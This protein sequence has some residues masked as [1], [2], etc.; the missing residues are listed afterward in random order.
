VP[1]ARAPGREVVVGAWLRQRGKLLAA[2][3]VVLVGVLI[4]LLVPRGPATGE[5]LVNITGPDGTAV[6]GVKVFLDERLVCEKSPCQLKDVEARGHLLM[7]E[8][9]G[10]NK[11][12]AIAVLVPE[13]ETK[14]H[15]VKLVPA[16]TNTGISVPESP[17]DITLFVDGNKIGSLPQRLDDLQPGEHSLRFTGGDRFHPLERKVTLG[18]GEVLPLDPVKLKV[19]LGKLTLTAGENADADDVEVLLRG[20]RVKLPHTADIDTTK[21]HTVIAGREGF[22]KFTQVVS[23]EDGNAELEMTIDLVP[24]EEAQAEEEADE[25]STKVAAAS[26][27]RARSSRR[28]TARRSTVK[29]S[30]SRSASSGNGKLTLLSVPPV[31]VLVDGRPVGKTPK[32]GLSV[33]AGSH[34]IVFVHPEKGRKRR[35]AKVAS[36]ASKTV[37]VRF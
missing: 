3:A 12:S 25:G 30:R 27:K 32:R 18:K 28:S 1:S 4:F 16:K 36:G 26:T 8:A 5:L 37:A 31:V 34:N 15:D 20:K 11:T 22:E 14:I 29:K 10:F 21:K 23:F 33:S 35:S 17:G 6:D 24:D 9:E 7:A 13:G 2:A 19:K